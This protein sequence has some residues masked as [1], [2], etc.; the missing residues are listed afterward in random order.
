MN[1]VAAINEISDILDAAGCATG[2][3]HVMYS[4]VQRV[5]DLNASRGYFMRQT[6]IAREG[7]KDAYARGYA[8]AK[9]G[10]EAADCLNVAQWTERTQPK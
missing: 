8:A 6:D 7:C 9:A 1:E 4:V 2:N 10:H 3:G 5:K